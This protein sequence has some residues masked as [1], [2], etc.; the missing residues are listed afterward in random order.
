MLTK[1]SLCC[2]YVFNIDTDSRSQAATFLKVFELAQFF[3]SSFVFFLGIIWQRLLFSQFSDEK[4]TFFRNPLTNISSFFSDRLMKF[5]FFSRSF[6][7]IRF[8]QSY[9]KDFS[10]SFC[11]RSSMGF[12][13]KKSLRKYMTCNFLFTHLVFQHFLR[14]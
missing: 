12:R 11:W 5:E 13:E 3:L 14:Y 7:N 6:V 9:S 8:W 10:L 4:T 2:K 1:E